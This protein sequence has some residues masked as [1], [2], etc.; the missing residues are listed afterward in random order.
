MKKKRRFFTVLSLGILLLFS[1]VLN[2]ISSIGVVKEDVEGRTA[3]LFQTIEQVEL[4]E[5]ILIN[6]DTYLYG[7]V[8]EE[9]ISIQ[10]ADTFALIPIEM[11]REVSEDENTPLY[12][13]SFKH[14]KNKQI[15][16]DFPL[17]SLEP[18]D[19]PRLVVN[20]DLTYPVGKNDFGMEVFY[21]A[22]IEF[23]LSEEDR[24]LAFENLVSNNTGEEEND[25]NVTEEEDQNLEEDLGDNNPI[26]DTDQ[27][28]EDQTL[29]PI[30]ESNQDSETEK[31]GIDESIQVGE[32]EKNEIN[33]SASPKSYTTFSS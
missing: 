16:K 24:I 14:E 12:H 31:D 32:T 2:P 4:D 9:V 25:N 5:G 23:Y 13:D 15:S 17:F 27:P 7:E 22:N 6:K 20:V 29:N 26:E 10:Y 11:V 19:N 21:F 28:T 30:N 18:N 8:Q 3:N 1:Q 33:E